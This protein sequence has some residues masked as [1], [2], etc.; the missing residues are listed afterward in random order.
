MSILYLVGWIKLRIYLIINQFIEFLNYI[1]LLSR[2]VSPWK[3]SCLWFWLV[4]L[5]ILLL[6]SQP[7]KLFTSDVEAAQ[8]WFI[9]NFVAFLI[10][11]HR[12]SDLLHWFLLISEA[13]QI[14]FWLLR[15]IKLH[16]RAQLNG[17]VFSLFYSPVQVEI[18]ITRAYFW[19][20]LLLLLIFSNNF[21]N[22]HDVTQ[23]KD[24]LTIIDLF[25]QVFE[26]AEVPS[27]FLLVWVARIKLV[28][29]FFS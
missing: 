16:R 23:V 10:D 17:F 24:A 29:F 19:L 11:F 1:R 6:F 2:S 13:R 25:E 7:G 12:S 21:L 14:A 26:L 18:L 8:V 27:L 4:L 22:V 9:R 5:H 3:S 28:P 15:C 20:L